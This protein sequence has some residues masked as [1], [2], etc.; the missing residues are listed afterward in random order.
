VP[1]L[2]HSPDIDVTESKLP[3]ASGIENSS[4]MIHLHFMKLFLD[5][6][7]QDL[8]DN[9][10]YPKAQRRDICENRYG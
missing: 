7:T 10:Y 5:C 9:R 2:Q 3:P 4:R 1:H 8:F 6:D